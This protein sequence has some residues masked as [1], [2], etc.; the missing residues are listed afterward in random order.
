[1]D[2]VRGILMGTPTL[3][4]LVAEIGLMLGFMVLMTWLGLWVFRKL[5]RYVS[6]KGTLGQH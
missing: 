5:E 4:P 1:L 3:L 2:A 6:Q